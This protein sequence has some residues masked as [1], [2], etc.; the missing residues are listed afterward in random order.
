M[1]DAF[2]T[3]AGPKLWSKLNYIARPLVDCRILGSIAA[4]EPHLR[5]C[6]ISLVPSRPKT[7]LEA[8]YV[9][10]ISKAWERLGLGSIPKAVVCKL[11]PFNR[12][13]EKA[14][15]KTVSLHAEMQLVMHYEERCAPRPTLDYFGCSKRT[16][17]LCETFLGELP[18]PIA[19]RGRHGVCYPAWAVPRSNPDAVE[20]AVERLEKNLVARIRGFLNDL[21]HPRQKIIAANVI[22]SDMVSEFSHL[23]LEEW[24]QREQ[25]VR[26]F[27]NKQTIQ[28]KD[29]LIVIS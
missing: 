18:S 5:N 16:C 23:T 4:R 26:L 11:D 17:L 21:M 22:Q 10:G 1:S 9:V 15:V 3:Q 13:F 7:A 2:G 25:D 29:K 6:K 24:R 28:H 19:T 14:C 20:V 27:K 12:R 8:K